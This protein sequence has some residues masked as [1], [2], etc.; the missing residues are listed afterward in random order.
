MGMAVPIIVL[1]LGKVAGDMFRKNQM[2]VAFLNG[3]SGL[4]LLFLS[5]SNLSDRRPRISDPTEPEV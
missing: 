2:I 3:G 1:T 4:A 5:V